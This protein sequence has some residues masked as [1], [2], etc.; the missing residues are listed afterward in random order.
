MQFEK[1]VHALDRVGLRVE[2]RNGRNNSVLVFV[3]IKSQRKFMAEIYR[4][5]FV[6]S[7]LLLINLS[8]TD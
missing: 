2:V 1:L 3:R 6:L 4:S 8:V 5:R 7:H